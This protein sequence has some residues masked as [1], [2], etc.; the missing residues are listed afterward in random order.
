[1]EIKI[2]RISLILQSKEKVFLKLTHLKL[3]R[4]GMINKKLKK[5]LL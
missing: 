5:N 3:K 2:Y 4:N 1:M